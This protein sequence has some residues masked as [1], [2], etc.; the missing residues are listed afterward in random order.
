M[1]PSWRSV[2]KTRGKPICKANL[3]PKWKC[4]NTKVALRKYSKCFVTYFPH[5]LHRFNAAYCSH[6]KHIICLVISTPANEVWGKVTFLHLYVILFTV[7]RGLSQPRMQTPSCRLTWGLLSRSPTRGWADSLWCRPPG[8][9]H[10]HRQTQMV[11]TSLDTVPCRQTWG[12]WAD[13]PGCRPPRIW[14]TSRR[15]AYYWNAYLCFI[16]M[17]LIY[18][19]TNN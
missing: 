2:E 13:P 19:V 11:Q 12:V 17:W 7:G 4:A 5:I 6:A 3:I 16:I 15:Y 8:C 9:R 14:S 18:F 1:K 10:P